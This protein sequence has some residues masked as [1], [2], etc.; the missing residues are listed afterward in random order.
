MP[1]VIEARGLTKTYLVSQRGEGFWGS[2]RGFFSREKRR[3]AA[4]KPVS[5]SIEPGELVA[6]LGPNGAGKTTTL[7]ML[8]GLLYPTGGELTVL[9]HRPFDKE[10]EFLRRFSFVM[11]QRHQLWWELPALDT[12]RLNA[13]V[14]DLDE[15]RYR[16]RLKELDELLQL[17]PLWHTPVK[18][19]S[20]GQRMK[21]ELACSLLHE[22]EL[23][24]LDEPTI[25]LDVVMQKTLRDF[26][27]RLN[28]EGKTTILLTSHNMEDIET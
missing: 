17:D 9:G 24:L 28:R 16:R 14:F 27:A 13:A 4:V 2:V 12:F 21:M 11:G 1:P 22:P 10:P 8:S 7:K 20:L 26:V 6:F 15:S 5:F 18:K 23:L 25:G 3:V 19:L